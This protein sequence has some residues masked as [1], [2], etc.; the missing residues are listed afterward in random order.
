M[1][2]LTRLKLSN[3]KLCEPPKTWQVPF[4]L[5]ELHL[6]TAELSK[7]ALNALGEKL[8]G[9]TS[10]YISCCER[11]TMRPSIA[12]EAITSLQ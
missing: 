11:E 8:S 9:L 1:S 5:K 12:L 6:E 7:A 4:G 2:A 3:G 10:L